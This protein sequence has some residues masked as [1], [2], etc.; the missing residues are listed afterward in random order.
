MIITKADYGKYLVIKSKLV[1][2]TFEKLSTLPGFKKWV[3]RDL[4]FDPTG[5]NID[6]IR[7]YFPEAEWDESAS[8]ALDQY[9]SNLKEMEANIQ[10][11]KA[12]LPSNDDY[13][14]K[15]KPFD[16]QRKA[17][18]MSRDKKSFALLME[19]GT[20]KT[21]VII[22]NAAYLY[23]KGE[24]TSLV[25]IAPNGVH[26]NWLK[27]LDIHMP[28]WCIRK[29]FYYSSGMTK[30]RIEEYDAVLGSSECLKIFTFNVEAFASPKA[31][32]YMQKI[33]VSNKTM[34]VVDES[35]RIKRP[36]AKRTKIITKFG[37][38]ADYKRI[39]TGTPVTKGPED[40]YSQFKFLDSQVLGYDSFYSF[41]ARYCV[42]G[43]FENKQIISYQNIDELTRNIE[44]HSFRVLKK[45][46]LDLPDK[47]YQRHY[48]E[49]TPKQKKLYQTMKKSFVA[50]LEGNMIEAPEAITRL[51]RLQQIL[52]GWFPSEGSVTQIDDKNP[53][54]EA[55]K[56]ILSDIDSKVIIWAR[57]KAD[58]RAIERALGD[59]AVSYHG[60]VTTDARE[61]AVDRFQNDPS[62]KYFIGQP[63]SG[64]IGLTL[65]AAD[66]AIYYSNSF[67]L[68]QRMQSED[69]CH[70]IGTK[71]NVTYIDIETRKSVDSKIIKALR[72]K[73]NLAD[74]ITKDPISLFMSEEDNE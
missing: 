18:Y 73:K 46:C 45:D 64:G 27:E 59:L 12:E 41:R 17:F 21:K 37:K 69:R 39:M 71:N 9:I 40:V 30:K 1:G 19:Q 35:S 26:R 70:R 22:D 13:D 72:E 57:F 65:T 4:L 51:L 8:P 55:L 67:D 16:H 15:T 14:F 63:Q 60:D 23:A 6:R 25:V 52:C 33:L 2:D 11:K 28:D 32:Y 10:M 24:I 48:V 50:E 58:L 29:S 56:E 43:G 36:G 38:Q 49:M 7:K 5:A 61:V 3:G 31:I 44:G 34:L 42:M 47:I 53:R 62:I 74:V 20:G 66:Y 68:E 54:I